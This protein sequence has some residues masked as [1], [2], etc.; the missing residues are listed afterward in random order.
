MFPYWGQPSRH[1]NDKRHWTVPLVGD[2]AHRWLRAHI[3]SVCPV[4]AG[5][6]FCVRFG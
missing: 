1:P 3:R 2:L 4:I 5:R 6:Q